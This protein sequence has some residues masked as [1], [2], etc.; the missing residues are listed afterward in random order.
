MNIEKKRA[1]KELFEGKDIFFYC[2][3]QDDEPQ[4]TLIL[5]TITDK[6]NPTF[7][8]NTHTHTCKEKFFFQNVTNKQIE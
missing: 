2:S 3:K 7:S 8:Y 1:R 6:K 5:L 4:N